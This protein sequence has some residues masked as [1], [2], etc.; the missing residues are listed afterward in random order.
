MVCLDELKLLD[1]YYL[2]VSKYTEAANALAVTVGKHYSFENARK[3]VLDLRDKC[4]DAQFALEQH[5]GEHNCGSP[6]AE[7]PEHSESSGQERA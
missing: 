5:R 7:I 3:R 4:Y 1:A 6:S 2:A